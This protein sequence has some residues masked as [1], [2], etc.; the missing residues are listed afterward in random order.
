M[1]NKPMKKSKNY[2]A[3]F[4]VLAVF[5][6]IPIINNGTYTDISVYKAKAFYYISALTL[7]L[8]AI[9]S[10][11]ED[12]FDKGN[13]ENNGSDGNDK[14]F[15]RESAFVAA[16]LYGGAV[17]ISAFLSG[18]VKE[19]AYGVPGFHMGA[20]SIIIMLI[21]FYYISIYF[22]CHDFVFHLI[23]AASVFPT[24]VAIANHFGMDPLGMFP[25]Y[26]DPRYS[27]YIST[28]G[29]YGWY[30]QYMAVVIPIGLYMLV[31][32][33]KPVIRGVYAGYMALAIVAT[34][35]CG[36]R[37]LMVTV[38]VSVIVVLGMRFGICKKRERRPLSSGKL[39]ILFVFAL[40]IYF[41]VVIAVSCHENLA[42]GRGYIWKLS[43]DLFH[44][45][46]I[47]EKIFGTGP[48][49]YMYALNEY[50]SRNPNTA[51]I[52][53]EHF[54][55]MALTSSHSELLDCLINTG[56]LGLA[57]YLYMIYSVFAS[58]L[59]TEGNRQ[60]AQIDSKINYRELA[61][62]AFLA[63]LT[64]SLG[65]F[66]IVCATPYFYVMMG[67]MISDTD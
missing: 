14:K 22:N 28:F 54:K 13:N 1:Y 53:N 6:V 37:M 26:A 52:F 66:M 15:F 58:F 31:M 24:I 25:E 4:Y 30:S 41:A 3:L 12:F 36:T 51:N 67:I 48:N 33:S 39:A 35:L 64:Y 44:D 2:I 21:S 11:F 63:Y 38:F 18:S 16:A 7:I 46:S 17:L 9:A 43:L 49:R 29:N 42:N 55:D 47:R 60:K 59:R 8:Y 50:L 27:L 23:V 20:L 65:N 45:F 40:V 32:T 62:T 57:A 19:S 10:F 61:F 56:G 34:M 5:W